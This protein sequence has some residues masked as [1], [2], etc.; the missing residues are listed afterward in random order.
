MGKTV[1]EGNGGQVWSVSFCRERKMVAAASEDHTIKLWDAT[2]AE[3]MDA[4]EG[5][6]AGVKAVAFAPRG[7][8]LASGA[9]DR[10]VK[11]WNPAGRV[12]FV[13]EGHRGSVNALAFSDDCRF[14]ASG[15]GEADKAGEVYLWD[16]AKARSLARLEGHAAEVLSVAIAPDRQTLVSGDAAG[17]VTLWDLNQFQ[18]QL[19]WTAHQGAVWT[20]AFHPEGKA[21]VTGGQDGRVK[22]WKIKNGTEIGNRQGDSSP[23]RAAAF[24]RHGR[25]LA[26]GC[27]DGHVKLWNVA[28]GG[29]W[30][31][32]CRLEK[33]VYALTYS[34]ERDLIAA[35]P[36][37]NVTCWH[38][39]TKEKMQVPLQHT[40]RNETSSAV[41]DRDRPRPQLAGAITQKL[42]ALIS[43][44]NK[45]ERET[46]CD[47]A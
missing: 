19:S 30:F 29:P 13:L 8:F 21:L 17:V 28:S 33:P 43:S 36:D 26:I 14:L 44:L 38:T 41:G 31:K 32:L 15:G 12:E 45:P 25:Q 34:P 35:G 7:R 5:H 11:M 27:L 24:S 1:L 47:V 10:L 37:Q 4:L 9:K 6:Q 16:L 3:A 20:L 39:R 46:T 22:F 40:T 2:T 23:I 42:Q 18:A